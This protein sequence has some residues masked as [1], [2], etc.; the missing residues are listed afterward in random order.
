MEKTSCKFTNRCWTKL[1]PVQPLL[2]VAGL[3]LA[4]LAG[5]GAA[6]AN[7]D[8]AQT[9]PTVLVSPVTSSISGTYGR[10][11]QVD[12]ARERLEDLLVNKEFKVVER[13]RVDQVLKE[14]EFSGKST[15]TD[16]EKAV[17]LGKA[18]GANV[19]VMGTILDVTSDTQNYNDGK[20]RTSKTVVNGSFRIRVVDM[21]SGTI[22]FSKE[23]ESRETYD[24]STNGAKTSSDA[25]SKVI[26]KA[27]ASAGDCQAFLDAI[28]G[29]S[30]GAT[31]SHGASRNEV[32]VSFEPTPSNCDILI[33]GDYRGS[34]PMKI[35]LPIGKQVKITIRKVG[36][37]P[38]EATLTPSDTSKKVTPA[39]DPDPQ[40]AKPSK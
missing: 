14:A 38:W 29:K 18:V 39:L 21:S 27:I 24:S 12:A 25:A 10:P 17:K 3:V 19:I 35:K 6:V 31:E 4:C 30:A 2:M 1:L 13:Q 40:D 36:R 7:A 34:S 33:D 5:P 20:I 16:S 11:A 22:T 26:K 32:E 23:F 9:S 8:D 15:L 37:A 28:K